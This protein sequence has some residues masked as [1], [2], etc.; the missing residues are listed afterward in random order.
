MNGLMREAA[1]QLRRPSFRKQALLMARIG[2][3]RHLAAIPV[4]TVACAVAVQN[5]VAEQ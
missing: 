1:I 5:S 2:A 3:Q 4:E